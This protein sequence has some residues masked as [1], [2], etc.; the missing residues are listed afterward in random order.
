[1]IQQ[2]TLPKFDENDEPYFEG[3]ED[4]PNPIRR[5]LPKFDDNDEMYFE[6]SEY[7]GQCVSESWP[8]PERQP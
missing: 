1:M 8:C 4:E 6:G 5:T 2:L 3:A 7:N